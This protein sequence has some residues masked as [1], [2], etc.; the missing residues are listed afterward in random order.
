VP[1]PSP[2]SH[3]AGYA[4][5]ASLMCSWMEALDHDLEDTDPS[6]TKS[7]PKLQSGGVP[8]ALAPAAP[9]SQAQALQG[10]GGRQGYSEFAFLKVSGRE[11]APSVLGSGDVEFW[12]LDLYDKDRFGVLEGKFGC[13]IT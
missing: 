10:G 4:H 8:A 11:G 12:G 6:S 5:M 2:S 9:A 1:L 7:T 3:F 13:V